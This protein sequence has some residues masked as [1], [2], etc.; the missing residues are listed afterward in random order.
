[1]VTSSSKEPALLLLKTV[2]YLENLDVLPKSMV[3][4]S[5]LHVEMGFI[6]VL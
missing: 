4:W 1:M 6:L 3:I 2:M 5:C